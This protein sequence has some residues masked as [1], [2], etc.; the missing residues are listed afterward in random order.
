MWEMRFLIKK[1]IHK[2]TR[3]SGVDD[4]KI[5]LD[6]IVMQEAERNKLLDVN[7]LKGA[8]GGI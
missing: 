3:A 4:P 7:V 5:L 8:G 2:F 6:P 1:D